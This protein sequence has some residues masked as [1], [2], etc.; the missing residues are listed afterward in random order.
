MAAL[1]ALVLGFPIA[2][3]ERQPSHC[4]AL[5]EADPSL[6]FLEKASFRDPLPDHTVRLHYIA[7]ASF[8][9]QSS[10]GV[11]A[12]TDYTGF[13]GR[14]DLVPDIVTMNRAH[15]THWTSTPDPRIPHILPGWTLD[16]GPAAHHLEHGDMLVRSVSTD[17]RSAGSGLGVNGN[18]I[19]IFEIAGLCIGHLGHLHHEPTPAQYAAIGRLDVVLAPVDGGMTLPLPVMIELLKRMRASLVIPMHWFGPS[20]LATFLAG[21]SDE[22]VI[23]RSEAPWLE[24]SLRSLPQNPTVWVLTPQ[25]LNDHDN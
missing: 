17:I 25:F 16:G 1:I 7:H 9:I 3:Q 22:F 11:S 4:I 13:L 14:T 15:E 12:V 2:A 8:L 20:N 6:I 18:S 19:F 10:G 23:E 5:A 24:I 21:M